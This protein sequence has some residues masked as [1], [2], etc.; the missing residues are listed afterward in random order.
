[1]FRSRVASAFSL[2]VVG[3]LYWLIVRE[4]AGVNE[5]WDSSAYWHLWYPVCLSL[6]ATAGYFLK[7]DGWLAGPV[8]VFA[9]LPIMWLNSEPDALL[10]LGLFLLCILAVPAVAVSFVAGTLAMRVRSD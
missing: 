3:G 4:V 6:S 8:L 7:Q 10:M 5:P 2:L 1:M 9:Q